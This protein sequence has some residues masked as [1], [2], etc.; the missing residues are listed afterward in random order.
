MKEW[1][2]LKEMWRRPARQW[3]EGMKEWTR[4]KEMWREPDDRVAWRKHVSRVA[5]NGPM[6]I[7]IQ[8]GAVKNYERVKLRILPVDAR[9]LRTIQKKLR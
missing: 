7:N 9:L 6:G 2:R 3:L 1:T 4:L 8:D 5:P